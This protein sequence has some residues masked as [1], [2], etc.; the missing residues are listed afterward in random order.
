MKRVLIVEES[1]DLRRLLLEMLPALFPEWE[2]VG[3]ESLE[4]AERL[5]RN[6]IF[7]LA[8]LD[9]D[10][11]GPRRG[12]DVLRDWTGAARRCPVVAATIVHALVPEIWAMNPAEVLLKPWDVHE[13]RARLARAMAS[14][15]AAAT[16]AVSVRADGVAVR[17]EF[18]FAGARITPDLRC[19]FPDG[20]AEE[21]GAKEYGILSC[22]A[23]APQELVLRE[24]VLREAWGSDANTQSNSLNVYLSR[25][26]RLFAE[27]GGDFERTVSTEAKVG[28]RIARR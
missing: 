7:A 17:D 3:A 15:A 27:H 5:H 10:Y 26:R 14:G 20:H 6:E 16:P 13:I 18:D 28:W 11:R 24:Q 4:E 25:L 23:H 12:I 21:L 2:T 1:R 9:V 19:R 8:V 22:F